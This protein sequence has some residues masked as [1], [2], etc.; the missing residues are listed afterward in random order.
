MSARSVQSYSG[1]RCSVTEC[2]KP[3][4]DIGMCSTHANRF[5]R[6]GD[7]EYRV[8][9]PGSGSTD[10]AKGYRIVQRPGHPVAQKHGRAYEHRV[11]LFDAIGPGEHLCHWCGAV[12]TWD[13]RDQRDPRFLSVD[14]INTVR[15]DNRTENLVPS[16]W[17]CN[18]S[19]TQTA[20]KSRKAAAR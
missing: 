19:R 3:A 5:R 8:A 13:V 12:V 18:A 4:R 17:P 9:A 10:K 20:T 1:V 14:H 2:E 7:L 6:N 11:V 16:C 15:T